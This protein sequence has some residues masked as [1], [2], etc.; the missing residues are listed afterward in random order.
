MITLHKFDKSLI[1]CIIIVDFK[2]GE[3][4]KLQKN[5]KYEKRI[6]AGLSALV[7][8]LGILTGCNNSEV[9]LEE[10]IETIQV[11]ATPKPTLIPEEEKTIEQR[12]HDSFEKNNF[13]LCD[14]YRISDEKIQERLKSLD[15]KYP[16]ETI[17][18]NYV[19]TLVAR[20]KDG[21]YKIIQTLEYIDSATNVMGIYD[22]FTEELLCEVSIDD[23]DF[24]Q[25]D[26]GKFYK[27]DSSL[28]TPKCEYLEENPIYEYGSAAYAVLFIQEHFDDIIAK[29]AE[30]G[31]IYSYQVTDQY[32]YLYT[33]DVHYDDI[34]HSVE[35]IAMNYV[36]NIPVEFQVSSSELKML[37][38]DK[39]LIK[40]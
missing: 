35:K 2:K 23:I 30:A 21:N 5:N 40:K 29:Y 19:G 13:Y 28:F 27:M 36:K 16:E 12:M 6:T 8:S 14:F 26:L 24:S 25:N 7:V 11:T 3:I 9:K 20:D 1:M 15:I 32:K 33:Y 22:I 10:P 31:K 39:T 38:N 17:T 18:M 37:T 4:M 34:E